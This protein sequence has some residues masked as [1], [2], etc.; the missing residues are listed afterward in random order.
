MDSSDEDDAQTALILGLIV[1]RRRRRAYSRRKRSVWVRSLFQKRTKQ[2]AYHNLLQEM[3]LS[4][5]ESH[6]SYLRMSKET[7]DTLLSMVKYQVFH[8]EIIV[9]PSSKSNSFNKHFRWVP[10]FTVVGTVVH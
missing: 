6:F 9:K 10:S 5:P 1:R 8:I 7:F 2:G 3:R 4:D